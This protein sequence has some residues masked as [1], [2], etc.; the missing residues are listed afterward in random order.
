MEASISDFPSTESIGTPVGFGAYATVRHYRPVQ[1]LIIAGN[2]ITAPLVIKIANRPELSPSIDR[3]WI[4]GSSLKRSPTLVPFYSYGK[5]KTQCSCILL[6]QLGEDLSRL[7]KSVGGQFSLDATFIIGMELL[8]GIE[9]V[10]SSGFC[11]C[12]IKPVR[13]YHLLLLFILFFVQNNFLCDKTSDKPQHLILIDYGCAIT[14]SSVHNLSLSPLTKYPTTRYTS[15]SVHT[16]VVSYIVPVIAVLF[17]VSRFFRHP[18]Q[19]TIYALGCSFSSN[20]PQDLFLGLTL[21]IWFICSPCS[22]FLFT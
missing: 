12:D 2:E 6:P 14:R 1:P 21:K 7:T 15:P 5:T 20:W 11:H 9:S 3:E 4:V 8:S 19:S 22:M 13:S 10:H 16:G 18:L 17:H